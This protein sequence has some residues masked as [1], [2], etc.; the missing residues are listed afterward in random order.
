MG[1]WTPRSEPVDAWVESYDPNAR[2]GLGW[3][4]FT[5]DPAKAVAF[6]SASEAL[7]YWQQTSTL[8]P[9]RDDGR[10]NRPLT[11]FTIAVKQIP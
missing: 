2:D 1:G 6:P 9:L 8:R 3:M 11:A 4:T 10:P 7:R 5:K